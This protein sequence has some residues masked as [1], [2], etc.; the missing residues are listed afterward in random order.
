VRL[1]LDEHYASQIALDLR[2]LGHDVDCVKERPSLI[3]PA[4][5]E[6][7][8]ALTMERRAL[9]TENVADFGPLIRQILAAGESHPGIIYSS[10]RSMPRSRNT[11]GA[12]VVALDAVMRRFPGEDDFANRTEWV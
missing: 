12:L 9:L 5:G 4:D 8:A 1:C 10:S 11:I 7:L 3:G 6:L 2:G